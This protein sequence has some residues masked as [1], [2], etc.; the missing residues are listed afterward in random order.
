M[1][2]LDRDKYLESMAFPFLLKISFNLPQCFL[3]LLPLSVTSYSAMSHCLRYHSAHAYCLEYLSTHNSPKP[4]LPLFALVLLQSFDARL[5]REGGVLR[6]GTLRSLRELEPQR[7]CIK[8]GQWVRCL[9]CLL[10][11]YS[12]SNPLIIYR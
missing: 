1:S 4:V 10:Q 5:N 11:A 6:S 8:R 12:H 3:V 9:F 7:I 2:V